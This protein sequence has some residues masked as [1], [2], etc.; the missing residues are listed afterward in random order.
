MLMEALK[1][2]LEVFLKQLQLW[3]MCL[4]VLNVYKVDSIKEWM[5]SDILLAY[6]LSEYTNPFIW[7]IQK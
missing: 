3:N 5:L 7:I 4:S 2:H 6:L 1:I